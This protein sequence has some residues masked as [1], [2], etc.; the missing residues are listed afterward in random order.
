MCRAKLQYMI[1]KSTRH[2]DKTSQLWML[3]QYYPV[4]SNILR[5]YDKRSTESSVFLLTSGTLQKY[6]NILGYVLQDYS[7]L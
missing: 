5:I 3:D 2:D 1:L 7:T 6:H 4:S